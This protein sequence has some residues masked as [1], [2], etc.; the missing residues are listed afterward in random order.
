MFSH[1]LHA[2]DVGGEIRAA[3][4]HL[5]GAKAL[6]EIVVG[7]LEQRLDGKVE[8]DA[9]GIAGHAGVEAAE[10]TEQRQTGAPRLQ[11]PQGDI[12]RRQRQHRRPAAPAVM[13]APPDVMP[14]RLGVVGFPA[15]DQLGDFAPEDIR[16]RAAVA[17]DGVG[18]AGAFSPVGIANAACHQFEGCDFAMRAVGEGYRQRDPIEPALDRL[19]QCH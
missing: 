1:R 4:L 17:A 2:R 3:H 5:D 9:A 18:V 10:Q 13:Q 7:L 11:V 15:F 19:D 6:G 16:D 14:D 12:E 8:V